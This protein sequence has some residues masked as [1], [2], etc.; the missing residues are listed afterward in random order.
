MCNKTMFFNIKFISYLSPFFTIF[1]LV[2]L[3]SA[4]YICKYIIN[5][6]YIKV[7]EFGK[8]NALRLG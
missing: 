7:T 6:C 3:F 8:V 2:L 1:A 5:I 4:I